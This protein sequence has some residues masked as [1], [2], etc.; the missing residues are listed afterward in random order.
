MEAMFKKKRM[1]SRTPH[2]NRVRLRFWFWGGLV[3]LLLVFALAGPAFM[4]HDPY[5]IDLT[6]VQ[7]APSHEHI[8]GTDTLGRCIACRMVEGA[9]RSIFAAVLVVLITLVVGTVIGIVSG[10]VG[11]TLDN[12]IMR[13]VDSF[14][15]FPSLIFTIAVAAM[16]GGSLTNCILA[17]SMVGWTGYARLARS[18]VLTVRERPYV[19][20][21]RV[22]GMRRGALLFQ[23]ILPNCLRPLI[24]SATTHVGSSILSFSGLSFLGLGTAPPYP[25]WGNMLND[26]RVH[27][28]TAPWAAIYPGLAILLVVV[29]MGMFGDSLNEYMNPSKTESDN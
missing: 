22:S 15:A 12:I 3:V 26:A 11:G 9:F 8:F 4:P 18:Q 14:Q 5:A 6:A 21:S 10:F 29:I 2:N 20:A 24:V 28:Q 7:Q 17:M 25:E 19:A 23:V 1:S 27:L 16:L 13:I